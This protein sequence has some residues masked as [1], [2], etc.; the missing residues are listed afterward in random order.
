MSIAKHF[1]SNSLKEF[2]GIKRL[3][4]RAMA[5]LNNEELH[6]QPSTESNSIA[7]IVKH[8][9]GNMLSRWT[10]FLTTDGEKPWR[11]RDVEF[12]GDYQSKDDLLAD[13]NKG[14]NVVFSTLEGLTEKD[15]L[16][17]I[18]IRGEDHS[19]IEAIH[20]QISHYG[21]HIG[22]IVFIA[23]QVKNTEFESLSIPKGKSQQF[24]EQKLNEAKQ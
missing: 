24:L 16:K 7:I 1:L 18:T 13:W 8:L 3:G 5:Q 20:R 9:S 6:W 11:N 21:Y 14:W 17:T 2:H 12:E 19:V 22:Q 23:K 4:D 10:D 15:V